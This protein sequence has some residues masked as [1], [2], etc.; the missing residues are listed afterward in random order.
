MVRLHW[1]YSGGSETLNPES[2][3]PR[4]HGFLLRDVTL[5]FF[6]IFLLFFD[7]PS[8]PIFSFVLSS[9]VSSPLLY[10]LPS[11]LTCH[12]PS[13]LALYFFLFLSTYNV[14]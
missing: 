12:L 5:L 7:S 2:S 11:F 8:S 1:S 13:P 14:I 3:K 6:N 4:T 9:F 10:S